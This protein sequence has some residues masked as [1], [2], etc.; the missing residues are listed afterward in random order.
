MKRL[1]LSES[2]LSVEFASR[3][4]G[5]TVLGCA[6][7][8]ELHLDTVGPLYDVQCHINELLQAGDEEA[9][10]DVLEEPEW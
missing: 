7:M 8:R 10:A 9:V 2:P 3:V 1:E 5:P 4:L 6:S